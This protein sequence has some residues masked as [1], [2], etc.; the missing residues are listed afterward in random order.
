MDTKA[1]A[2]QKNVCMDEIVA[3]VGQG[4]VVF[5]L[6]LFSVMLVSLQSV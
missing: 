6:R 1:Q 4:G 5:M 3:G 2:T